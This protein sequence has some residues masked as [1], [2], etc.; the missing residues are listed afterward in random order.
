MKNV[1]F[2]KTNVK[3]HCAWRQP[4]KLYNIVLKSV[5]RLLIG[6]QPSVRFFSLWF[7]VL[8]QMILLWTSFKFHTNFHTGLPLSTVDFSCWGG[9]RLRIKSQ[10]SGVDLIRCVCNNHE[11]YK[12][13]YLPSHYNR[14]IGPFVRR[15]WCHHTAEFIYACR[16]GADTPSSFLNDRCRHSDKAPPHVAAGGRR[17]NQKQ[18]NCRCF[19]NFFSPWKLKLS[20]IYITIVHWCR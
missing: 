4:H 20:N 10:V 1:L 19:S 17:Q 15:R 6:S 8:L 11:S 5:C 2:A 12:D 14:Y 13:E 16:Y 18:R 3:E 7:E 9:R